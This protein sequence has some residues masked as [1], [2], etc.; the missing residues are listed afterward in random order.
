[1]GDVAKGL[2]SFKKGMA[3]E[4]AEQRRQA[5]RPRQTAA[6]AATRRRRSRPPQPR[7]PQTPTS[8]RRPTTAGA[9]PA[10][11]R[12]MF[13]ID[14]GEFLVIAVVALVVIGPKDLPRVMRVVGQCVGRARGM[15]TH[16]RCRVRH[17]DP[18]IRARG[19]GEEVEEDNERI[20]REHPADGDYPEP[21][22]EQAGA[23]AK[24]QASPGDAPTCRASA[25]AAAA[26]RRPSPRPASEPL[27]MSPGDDST[28][29]RRR[30]STI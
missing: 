13:G 3:D 15:A 7:R 4:E 16:F 10:E 22:D 23:S 5:D 2:K 1:M 26:A 30:C 11:G 8:C 9:K 6:A 27:P 21:S 14:S 17:H 29:A 12:P 28:R 19:H 20:M 25:P 24:R 18:R